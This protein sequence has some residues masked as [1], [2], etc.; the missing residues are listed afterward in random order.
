M[1]SESNKPQWWQLYV[2]L[3]L[4]VGLYIP[5]MRLHLTTTEHIVAQMGILALIYVFLH[6]WM[7][8]NRRALMGLDE[9]A[10]ERLGE[11]RIMVYEVPSAE[12]PKAD[13]TRLAKPLLQLP[14]GGVKGVLSTTFER[15]D[16]EDE[17]R[18]PARMEGL[19]SD[20]VLNCQRAGAEHAASQASKDE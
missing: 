2:G 8:G 14:E 19:F 5:E 16:C 1:S 17:P 15:D 13:R 20:E 3:P 12:P 11:W 7:R 18:Y 10:D 6:A 9:R 4:L